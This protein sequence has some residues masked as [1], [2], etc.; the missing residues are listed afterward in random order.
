MDM[1]PLDAASFRLGEWVVHPGEGSLRSSRASRRLEP[2]LM[3][4]LVCLASQAGKVVTK[5]EIIDTVW[6]G[7]VTTNDA[8]AAAIY[9]LRKA[10]G[11]EAR[12]PR[13]VETIPKRGYRVLS[14]PALEPDAPKIRSLAVLPLKT[15]SQN[16][17]GDEELA[18]GLTAALINELAR[19]SSLRVISRTS[20]QG[21]RGTA[22]D[23][24]EIAREL[25]VD[26]ILEGTVVRSG[27]R[28]RIDSQLVDAARDTYLWAESYERDLADVFELQA[29]IARSIAR[30]I[31]G[32]VR[33]DQANQTARVSNEAMEAYLK[34]L[35]FLDTRRAGSLA[36]AKL[37]FERALTL[38]PQFA[39]CLAGLASCYVSMIFLGQRDNPELAA[40]AK[41]AALQALALNPH[42]GQAH[43]AYAIV[44]GFAHRNFAAAEI[45]FQRALSLQPDL[46]RA[47][48][49]YGLMLVA[50]GRAEEAA[51]QCDEAQRLDPLNLIAHE[52]L[53]ETRFLL[54]QYDRVIED[55]TKVVQ[56]SPKHGLAYLKIALSHWQL[57]NLDGF[58]E[59]YLQGSKSTGASE[60]YL[61]ELENG[62]KKA[63]A[64]GLFSVAA[65]LAA[66]QDPERPN[67]FQELIMANA[68][69]GNHERALHYLE[70][71]CEHKSPYLAWIITAPY[72]DG[73]RRDPRFVAV[74]ARVRACIEAAPH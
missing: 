73:L 50:M 69:A 21:Y 59:N 10:L 60:F 4:L 40:H 29:D 71:A 41:Q 64:P 39:E 34:G 7:Q 37:Y 45:E 63:G 74:E 13:Y 14:I 65:I 22:K 70:S 57:G 27:N 43:A 26:A 30:E 12:R 1:V 66:R 5:R 62:F 58:L 6:D 54:R 20:V 18:E 38:E 35:A 33:P 25:H 2:Q 23:A 42:L 16:V 44:L 52:E 19:L 53:A 67:Q 47:R 31:R 15:A 61:R 17:E 46:A 28:V 56:L 11:D 68:A 8:V 3:K 55:M 24:P 32:L 48:R 36:Q 51:F 9:S 72:L 49:R